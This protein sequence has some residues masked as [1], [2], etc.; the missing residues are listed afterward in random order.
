MEDIFW[1]CILD[2]VSENDDYSQVDLESR[3]LLLTML[4]EWKR[5]LAGE[6]LLW[7][8][9]VAWQVWRCLWRNH[10]LW[11]V[12]FHTSDLPKQSSSGF[13]WA[14]VCFPRFID[15][16]GKAGHGHMGDFSA[17]RSF[18][19]FQGHRSNSLINFDSGH[20]GEAWPHTWCVWAT[21]VR[22][23]RNLFLITIYSLKFLKV[24]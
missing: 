23:R 8:H 11:F 10:H 15:M 12:S 22:L 20:H 1:M 5:H 7:L 2:M 18:L 24:D 9:H 17:D 21:Q 14:G 13:G 16:Q 6:S 4:D 3:R 19:R